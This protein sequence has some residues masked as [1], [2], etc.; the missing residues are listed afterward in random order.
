MIKSDKKRIRLTVT[1]RADLLLRAQAKR[2]SAQAGR[3]V[4]FDD[5]MDEMID[6]MKLKNWMAM[7]ED[8]QKAMGEVSGPVMNLTQDKVS[9]TWFVEDSEFGPVPSKPLSR[10][11]KDPR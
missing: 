8:H 9:A 10:Q 6:Q 11:Q 3:P 5:V 7:R 4:S 2:C 1:D